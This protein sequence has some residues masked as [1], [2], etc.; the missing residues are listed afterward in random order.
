MMTSLHLRRNAG[1]RV[2]RF[3]R[4]LMVLVA[5]VAG[6]AT[7]ATTRSPAGIP[8]RVATYNIRSGNGDLAGTAA[9]IRALR[10]DVVALQEVDVHWASRSDYADQATELGQRLGMRVRF[11]PIYILPDSSVASARGSGRPPREFGVALLSRFPIVSFANDTITRL[12]TQVQNPV[13]TPMPGL[14]DAV[15][16]VHGVRVH[17]LNTHLDYRRDPAARAAQ[18]REMLTH[19]D[20][21]APT[22]VFGDMNAPPTA[23]ELQPLLASLHDVLHGRPDELTYPADA[24]TA[25]DDY[26]LTSSHFRVRDARVPVTQASDHRPVVASLELVPGISSR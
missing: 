7:A 13:P 18:V 19:V 26:I 16:D 24:P 6:C 22:L 17:V 3:M 15:L 12:S 8:L 4:A 9:A 14:L 2:Q 20:T 1:H 23:P 25:R 21:A 11:A 5:A 10:A